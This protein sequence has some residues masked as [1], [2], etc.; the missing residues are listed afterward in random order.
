MNIIEKYYIRKSSL[1]HKDDI[2]LRLEDHD[3]DLMRKAQFYLF[4][5]PAAT[6]GLIYFG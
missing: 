4:F 5:A 1:G 2:H 6:F 3:I